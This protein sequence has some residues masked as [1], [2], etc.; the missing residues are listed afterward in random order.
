M[1]GAVPSGDILL[2]QVALLY[3]H[4]RRRIWEVARRG[5]GRQEGEHFG[6][7]IGSGRCCERA[8]E[9]GRF[10]S[11][12]GSPWRDWKDIDW[13]MTSWPGEHDGERGRAPVGGVSDAPILSDGDKGNTPWIRRRGENTGGDA[14]QGA[15]YEVL[16]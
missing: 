14:E 12:S 11:D 7:A 10:L 1:R 16:V 6:S 3:I 5:P 13:D 9:R 8:S 2:L 4:A 15:G